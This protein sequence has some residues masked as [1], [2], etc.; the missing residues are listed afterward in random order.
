MTTQ[1][2]NGGHFFGGGKLFVKTSFHFSLNL[3]YLGKEPSGKAHTDDFKALV[4]Q[5]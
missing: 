1:I 2:S 5:N 3:W 4:V